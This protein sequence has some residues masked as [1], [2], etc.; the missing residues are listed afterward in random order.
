[1][2]KTERKPRIYVACLA[3]Y[4]SGRLYGAWIDADQPA[5]EIR[6]EVSAMLKASP[7]AQAEEFG[8]HDYDDF[9]GAQ[10]CEYTDLETVSALAAFI[11]EH[12]ELGGKLLS[13]L[14][15]LDDAQKAMENHYAGCHA[16]LAGFAQELTE[17]TT[18]IPEPLRFYIDYEAMA[19]DFEINDV[20]TIETAYDE[21]H[22][23]WRH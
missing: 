17:E 10:L 1:M 23:F 2:C 11:A 9:A 8:I 16:S 4:N 20:F 15:D 22:V 6:G 14:G 3:A 18:E 7:I 19:R 21:V 12:G 5:D 13:Y